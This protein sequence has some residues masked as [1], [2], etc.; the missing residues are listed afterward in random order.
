MEDI[1]FRTLHFLH[2]HTKNGHAHQ[3]Q[4]D[5]GIDIAVRF[6]CAPNQMNYVRKSRTLTIGAE[7]NICIVINCFVSKAFGN[8]YYGTMSSINLLDAM[9]GS[10][11]PKLKLAA[12]MLSPAPAAFALWNFGDCFLLGKII[13]LRFDSIRK[14]NLLSVV[15]VFLFGQFLCIFLRFTSPIWN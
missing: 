14:C 4:S 6:N 1:S 13:A 12:P 7:R 3:R 8:N 11:K 10:I 2:R 9:V 15:F 5:T